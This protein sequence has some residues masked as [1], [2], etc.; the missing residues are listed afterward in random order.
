ML[1]TNN[2]IFLKRINSFETL[3]RTQCNNTFKSSQLKLNCF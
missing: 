2:E 3:S 1:T